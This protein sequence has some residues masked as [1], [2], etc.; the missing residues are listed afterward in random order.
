MIVGIWPAR[1]ETA[2]VSVK[3]PPQIRAAWLG[4]QQIFPIAIRGFFFFLVIQLRA[5]FSPLY[6]LPHGVQRVLVVEVDSS[7]D[8]VICR[9][10]QSDARETSVLARSVLGKNTLCKV[11]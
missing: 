11:K 8:E 7:V 9:D 2:P 1:K 10:Y 4:G 6:P 5:D 3:G